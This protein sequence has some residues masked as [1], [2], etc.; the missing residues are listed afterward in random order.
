M[1][2]EMRQLSNAM[3]DMIQEINRL[4]EPVYPHLARHIQEECE[5]KD[6]VILELGP[7]CGVIFSLMAQ[8][9]GG[10]FRIGAFPSG[11]VPFYR[12][13]VHEKGFDEKISVLETDQTLAGIEDASIDLVVFRGALFFPSLFQV[14]YQ[15]ITRVIKPGGCAMIGG[16][17]GKL[18]PPEV[19]RPIAD[20]SKDLNLKIGKVEVTEEQ[21]RHEIDAS[22]V[23]I[24]YRIVRDGGL[25][26]IL[27]KG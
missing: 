18:T 23:P 19:I 3:L 17:F 5:R 25:W 6:G 24:H 20:R 12:D 13:W 22:G 27:N 1:K 9:M 21:V 14:D 16:G 7:F 10:K 4:W 26:V 11:I 8:D 15:A 2:D